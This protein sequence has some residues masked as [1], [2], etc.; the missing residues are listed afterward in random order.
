MTNL[1]GLTTIIT[2]TDGRASYPNSFLSYNPKEK[3]KN[4]YFVV[5]VKEKVNDIEEKGKMLESYNKFMRKNL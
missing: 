3:E 4:S 2:P 5:L 1:I